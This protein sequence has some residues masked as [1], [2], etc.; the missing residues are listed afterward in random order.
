[1]NVATLFNSKAYSKD[2]ALGDKSESPCVGISYCM[3]V[4]INPDIGDILLSRT[5]FVRC[6]IFTIVYIL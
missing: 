3:P 1:M 6:D 2:P 5:L 4:F